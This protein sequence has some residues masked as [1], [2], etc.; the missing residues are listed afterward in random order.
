MVSPS[1]DS[2]L[3]SIRSSGIEGRA[4]VL[5]QPV[6]LPRYLRN[7]QSTLADLLMYGEP[8]LGKIGT[9]RRKRTRRRENSRFESG[10]RADRVLRFA[11]GFR[12]HHRPRAV[13]AG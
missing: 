4:I 1:P 6:H 10:D 13:D 12:P 2:S 9:Q 8:T 5:G 11:G 7:F 3:T